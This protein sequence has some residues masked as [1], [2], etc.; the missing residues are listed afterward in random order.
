MLLG[1]LAF[2]VLARGLEDVE[3]MPGFELVITDQKLH[4]QIL[5]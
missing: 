5:T 2:V 1:L 3:D 4:L